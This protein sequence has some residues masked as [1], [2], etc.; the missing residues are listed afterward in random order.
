MASGMQQALSCVCQMKV[1]ISG[2]RR[3]SKAPCLGPSCVFLLLAL[4]LLLV[5]SCLQLSPSDPPLHV[6]TLAHLCRHTGTPLIPKQTWG[7]RLLGCWCHLVL[8]G[9][10]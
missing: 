9:A 6:H 5:L 4:G 7:R 3:R 8:L 1:C 10:A 2:H